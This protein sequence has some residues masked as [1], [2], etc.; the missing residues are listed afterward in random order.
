M[1]AQLA[2][3]VD[4]SQRVV[5]LTY[6]PA[7]GAPAVQI[8]ISFMAWKTTTARVLEAEVEGEQRFAQRDA[9]RSRIVR[10]A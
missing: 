4:A 8:P 1:D 5:L 2:I 6:T 7:P 9:R 3:D 10:P